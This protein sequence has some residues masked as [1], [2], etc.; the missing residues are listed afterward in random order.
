MS[1]LP[2]LA[3]IRLAPSAQ[4]VIRHSFLSLPIC[5]KG[6]L[7]VSVTAVEWLSAPAV[8]LTVIV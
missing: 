2:G 8:P 6:Q 5:R 4:I 3:A 1:A 7:T